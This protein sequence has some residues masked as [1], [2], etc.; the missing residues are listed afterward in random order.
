MH[1]NIVGEEMDAHAIRVGSGV[2]GCVGGG[3]AAW[4]AEARSN[5]E[6]ERRFSRVW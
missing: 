1:R 3:G 5:R 6:R 2:G 4:V